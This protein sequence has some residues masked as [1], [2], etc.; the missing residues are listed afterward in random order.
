[1]G[2]LIISSKQYAYIYGEWMLAIYPQAN[3][4]MVPILVNL[5]SGLWT[6]DLETEFA[7][8][9]SVRLMQAALTQFYQVK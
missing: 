2:E 1:M 9:S 4:A 3:G 7:R 5:K 6:N 8:K